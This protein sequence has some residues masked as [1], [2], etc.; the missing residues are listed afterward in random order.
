MAACYVAGCRYQIA[1]IVP[2]AEIDQKLTTIDPPG[3]LLKIANLHGLQ[4]PQI[5]ASDRFC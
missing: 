1:V 5:V 3:L 4:S 2:R